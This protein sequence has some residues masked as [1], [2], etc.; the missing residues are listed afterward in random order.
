[1]L[2]GAGATED[3][4]EAAARAA[5]QAAS[6]LRHNGYKVPL[7]KALLKRALRTLSDAYRIG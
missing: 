2:A 5:L 1:M 7:A 3:G 4:F 6:P